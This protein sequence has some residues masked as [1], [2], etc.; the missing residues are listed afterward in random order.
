MGPPMDKKTSRTFYNHDWLK[1][2]FLNLSLERTSLVA[3]MVKNP[4]VMWD[5][6]P[7]VRSL[8]WEDHLKKGNATHSS[9]LA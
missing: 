4:P 3:Q 7:Q 6:I 5:L 1:F 9:I 8:S 2:V